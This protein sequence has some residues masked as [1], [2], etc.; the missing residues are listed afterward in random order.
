MNTRRS[1]IQILYDML[2][3]I[4]SAELAKPT[5]IMYKANLSYQRF[6]KYLELL[7]EKEFVTKIKKKRS[8]YFQITEKGRKFV[9]SFRQV[10]EFSEAFGLP[11]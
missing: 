1:K 8:T 6:K 2:R 5:H 3:F 7:E 4:Q 10:Q 9:R 11:I